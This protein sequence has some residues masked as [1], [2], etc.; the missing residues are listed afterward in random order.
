MFGASNAVKQVKRAYA[1]VVNDS[2]VKVGDS[3]IISKA[4]GVAEVDNRFLQARLIQDSFGN[5]VKVKALTLL[6]LSKYEERKA[7]SKR[8]IVYLGM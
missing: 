1:V 8:K 5:K 6:Q 3:K 2:I 7:D 4:F